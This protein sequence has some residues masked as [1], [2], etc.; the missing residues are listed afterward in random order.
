MSCQH[1]N[2]DLTALETSRLLFKKTSIFSVWLNHP[3]IF[4]GDFINCNCFYK[5]WYKTSKNIEIKFLIKQKI[6]KK[7]GK[8]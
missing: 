2:F 6:K 8:N 5:K 1:Y 4:G 3:H 7:T